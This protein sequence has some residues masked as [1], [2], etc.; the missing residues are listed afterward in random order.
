MNSHVMHSL[1]ALQTWVERSA[2]LTVTEVWVLGFI[3]NTHTHTHTWGGPVG[4]SDRFQSQTSLYAVPPERAQPTK[5]QHFTSLSHVYKCHFLFLPAKRGFQTHELNCR[6][7][8]KHIKWPPV[9][10]EK[11]PLHAHFNAWN[12]SLFDREARVF[13]WIILAFA[14][15]SSAI[16]TYCV[17]VPLK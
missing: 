4:Q 13:L 10:A 15:V 7:F 6:N 17:W 3:S 8:K 12:R 9:L 5:S 14:H 2:G 16:N 1:M 11:N